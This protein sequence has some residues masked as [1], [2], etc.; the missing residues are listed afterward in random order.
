MLLIP[1]LLY[2][3]SQATQSSLPPS[4]HSSRTHSPVSTSSQHTDIV[5]PTQRVTQHDSDQY[6]ITTSDQS[7]TPLMTFDTIPVKSKKI[8]GGHDLHVPGTKSNERVGS[9]ARL[10]GGERHVKSQSS[11]QSRSGKH[12]TS[13]QTK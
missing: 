4:L 2:R 13:V 12:R 10:T 7:A 11:K 8:T 6:H 5:Q 9:G 1:V 3:R